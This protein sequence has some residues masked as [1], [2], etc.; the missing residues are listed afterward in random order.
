MSKVL[1]KTMEESSSIYA[2]A[3]RGAH[4]NFRMFFHEF[5]IV[6]LDMALVT[7]VIIWRVRR[8]IFQCKVQT[9]VFNA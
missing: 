5:A 1:E 9:A 3:L 2:L 7:I 8:S 6:C 4:F